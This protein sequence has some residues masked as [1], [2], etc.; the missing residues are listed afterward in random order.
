MNKKAASWIA[1]I[2]AMGMTVA[3]VT[4][5]IIWSK[6]QIS[7]LS[8]DT[9]NYVTGKEECKSVRID[10]WGNAE[11]TELTI[12]NKGYVKISSVRVMFDNSEDNVEMLD[13]EIL[14]GSTENLNEAFTTAEILPIIV[15]KDQTYGCKDKVLTISC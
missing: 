11:C 12:E 14:P 9:V 7:E 3:L 4:G 13:A 1:W 6:G 2:L 5:M 8:E 10:A 15:V